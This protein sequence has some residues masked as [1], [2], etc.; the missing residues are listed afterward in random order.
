MGVAEPTTGLHGDVQRV[1]EREGLALQPQRFDDLLE[2]RAVDELHHDEVAIV[3]LPDVEDADDVGVAEP[4]A[5]PSLVEEHP[6][7]VRVRRQMRKHALDRDLLLEALNASGLPEEH[8]GHASSL[9][10]LDQ[11]ISLIAHRASFAL[12]RGVNPLSFAG[13]SWVKERMRL[14]RR[15]RGA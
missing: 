8:L 1:L 11:V 13:P 4:C 9:E 10:F 7:E 2:V 14:T 15:L 6:D 3:G 12:P 5:E